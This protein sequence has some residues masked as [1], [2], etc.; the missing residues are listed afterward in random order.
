MKEVRNFY[1]KIINI[2]EN[3]NLRSDICYID[4]Q[5]SNYIKHL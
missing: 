5:R 1:E 4:I 2:Q 3:N